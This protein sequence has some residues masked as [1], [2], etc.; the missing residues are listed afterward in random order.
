MKEISL[1][2]QLRQETG[3]RKIKKYRREGFVP[4]VV[5]G[6]KK[7]QPTAI[8]VDR[9]SYE[10]IMRGHHGEN[11]VF[12]LN[13]KEGDNSVRDYSAIVKEEQHEP[14]LERLMH[15]DFLRISLKEAIEVDVSVVA[16]GEPVGVK[17]DGGSLEHNLWE[18]DVICLPTNIPNKLE[19]DVSH[20]K[21]GDTIHVKD[22]ILP[23]GVKT[24]HDPEAIVFSVVPPMKEEIETEE[25]SLTEPEVIKEKKE[26]GDAS[27]EE[28]SEG[29]KE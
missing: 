17:A 21:I 15:I 19:V 7:K 16:K 9:R 14:V 13:V 8:N 22:V 23:E 6:G 12:H 26:K 11:V 27:S 29:K 28:K 1:D 25:E 5:Y 20:L 10:K 18:L 3:S 2:V 24:K 4:A